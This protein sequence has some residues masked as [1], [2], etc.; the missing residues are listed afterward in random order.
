[1]LLGGTVPSGASVGKAELHSKGFLRESILT[2]VGINK[3][4]VRE[5]ESVST[6]ATG[7]GVVASTT[8]ENVGT[9]AT[10]KNIANVVGGAD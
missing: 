6:I 1:M 9:E 4:L 10:I 7:Q 5:L 3:R 2:K 8:I